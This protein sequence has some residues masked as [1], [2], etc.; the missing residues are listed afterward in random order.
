MIKKLFRIL[1]VIITFWVAPAFAGSATFYYSDGP[2]SGKV[3]DSETKEPIEGAVVLAVWQKV[4][5]TP[6][7]DSSYF[8]DAVEVLTDKDGNFLIPKFKGI[9]IN[10]LARIEGPRFTIYKPS[11]SLFPSYM[12]FNTYFPNSPLRVSIDEMEAMFIKGVVV[13]LPSLKTKKERLDGL[14]SSSDPFHG[15][16]EKKKHYVKL[17]NDE[18]IRLGLEPVESWE[19]KGK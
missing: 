17:L 19:G 10:P 11:Y 8:L 16:D 13:E 9:N 7:G 15:Y 14:P 6:T 3:I 5:A 1:V 2:W 18:R 4:Y 12:Y